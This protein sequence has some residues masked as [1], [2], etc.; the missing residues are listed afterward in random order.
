MAS[1]YELKFPVMPVLGVVAALTGLTLLRSR[2]KE[3]THP[4]PPGP[5]GLPIIGSA[6]KIDFNAPHLTYTDWANQYGEIVYSRILGDD[7]ILVNTERAVRA[8][9]EG[10]RSAIYASRPPFPI[11]KRFGVDFHTA[12]TPYGSEWRAHRAILQQALRAGSIQ[13]YQD[14][15]MS[16]SYSLAL[17]LL[18][19][20]AP[21][22]L[23]KF[24]KTF[25]AS[26]ALVV[27]YGYHAEQGDA[28]VNAA[29]DLATSVTGRL[30]PEKAAL[31][32]KVPFLEYIP[33]FMIRTSYCR[34]LA[35]AVTDIPYAFLNKELE[36]GTETPSAMVDVLSGRKDSKRSDLTLKNAAATIHLAATENNAAT[37]QIFVLT[38]FLFGDKQRKAQEEIDRV[39]GADRLPTYEDRDSLPYIEALICESLRWH[40]SVPMGVPHYLTEDDVFEG[41]YIPKGSIVKFNAWAMSRA[42][43]DPETFEPERH[44]L[45][46][47]EVS[48][49]SRLASSF[50]YGNFGFGRR[51][52]PGRVYAD[53]LLWAAV[54]QILAT[55]TISRPRDAN[56]KEIDYVPKWEGGLTA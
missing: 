50:M 30:S 34:K 24:L 33:G 18:D 47:G 26:T 4:Y 17:S 8:L 16:K 14:L 19:G 12:T 38:M 40:P 41:H 11:I 45:P 52:C 56:G 54:V 15:F 29:Q 53:N 7:V 31:I 27:T 21:E 48:P 35:A 9:S 44:L 6:L 5:S 22:D 43:E 1:Y 2:R 55:V 25:A 36:Q 42:C 13:K 10:Q 20:V 32:Q 51:A 46:D 49:N 28:V 23:G 3:T 37:L 39:V